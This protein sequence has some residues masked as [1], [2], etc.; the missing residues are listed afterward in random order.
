MG[1][2]YTAFIVDQT[3]PDPQ[4]ARDLLASE[5]ASMKRVRDKTL[6]PITKIVAYRS[7]DNPISPCYSTISA[8]LDKGGSY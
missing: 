5:V 3:K 8:K 6:G 1:L 7:V 4:V 2:Q